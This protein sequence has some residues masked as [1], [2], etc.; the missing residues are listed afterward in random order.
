MNPFD[1]FDDTPDSAGKPAKL[2][3][4]D[5]VSKW[6][7]RGYPEAAA[8]GIADNMMRESGGNPIDVGDGGTSFGLF[9]HHNERK[10]ALE[11]FAKAHGKPASDPDIQIDFADQEL[12]KDYPKLRANLLASEDRSAAEDQFKR[13]FERPA[14]VMWSDG[15]KPTLGTKGYRFSDFAMNEHAGRKNTDIVYMPPQDYLDLSPPMEGSPF[16]TASGKALKASVA[17]GDEVESI[18]SLDMKVN[19]PTGTVTA[20]DGRHR[21]MMAQEEGLDAIPVAI[22]RQGKGDPTEIEGMG[23]KVLPVDFK[24]ASVVQASR[25]PEGAVVGQQK[26]N[27]FDQFDENAQVDPVVDLGMFGKADTRKFPFDQ[28]GTEY[29]SVLPFSKDASGI[30]LAW[31]EAVRSPVRGMLDMA[32]RATHPEAANAPMSSDELSAVSLGVGGGMT[33]E[34]N[35]GRGVAPA[36]VAAEA[37]AGKSTDTLRPMYDLVSKVL[38]KDIEK[39]PAAMQIVARL[40]RDATAGGPKAEDII[41]LVNKTP[42]KPLTL[43]DVGG[44]N[45]L[46]LAGKVARA[47]GESAE[48]MSNFLNPRDMEAGVRLARDVDKGI[49]EGSAYDAAAALQKARTVAARPIYEQ[50]YQYRPLNPDE[51]MPEG[52]IGALLDRPS[53]KAGMANARKIAAEEG[54][55]MNTL[56][57]DL[58]A[59]GEPFFTKVPSWQTLDYVKRG[60]DN[61]VEQYR[62]KTTGKLVLDTYGNAADATRTD[63]RTTLIFL[64]PKLAEAY[65]AYSGPSQ[66]LDAIK[67]GQSFLRQRPEEIARRLQKMLANDKE[68]Y[69]L[70]AADTLRQAVAKKGVD[71]DEAK[72]ILRSQY[73]RDQLHPLFEDEAAYDRFVSSV[74]AEGRMF[75]TRYDVLKN[76]QTAARQMEDFSPESEAAALGARSAAHAVHGNLLSAGAAALKSLAAFRSMKDPA[77]NAD[78]A[79]YLTTPMTGGAT[80]ERLNALKSVILDRALNP[81]SRPNVPGPVNNALSQMTRQ[82]MGG[83]N[84]GIPMS[85]GAYNPNQGQQQ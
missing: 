4:D 56:G 27:P 31:P 17:R 29:G 49:G 78:I 22:H 66:S 54:R 59:Q 57:I 41:E 81:Q 39:D 67:A 45:V 83:A 48:T 82:P 1:Q 55:D 14:S 76:S 85:V 52:Q 74:E 65:E 58:N 19:G 7:A 2:T 16:S 12:K 20:Q 51:M 35:A 13:V 30:H 40:E 73:M 42:E 6:T 26:S 68:F 21:A 3:Y 37:I 53:M 8:K 18:P 9:Q 77:I 47:P 69:K 34:M 72:A 63:F 64:N 75:G 43:S 71:G 80:A 11:A 61:V 25:T 36:K 44:R 23:G 33:S 28:P 5:M 46:G 84:I 32:A 24:P 50:A 15:A 10:T 38:G 70:G 62:D 79:R 60:V